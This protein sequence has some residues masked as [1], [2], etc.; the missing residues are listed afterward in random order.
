MQHDKNRSAPTRVTRELRG[1]ATVARGGAARSAW[2]L[3][4]AYPQLVSAIWRN[5]TAAG[6]LGDVLL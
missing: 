4:A 1:R 6:S 3:C 5:G 2:T